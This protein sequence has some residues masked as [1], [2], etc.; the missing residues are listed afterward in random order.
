MRRAQRRGASTVAVA[1]AEGANARGVEVAVDEFAG[2]FTSGLAAACDAE[3]G[4]DESGRWLVG[5]RDG[6]TVRRLADSRRTIATA[7]RSAL[8]PR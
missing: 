5:R 3:L 2:P 8:N 1:V 7:P 6:F 4:G